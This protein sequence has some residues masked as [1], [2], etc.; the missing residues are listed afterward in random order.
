MERL[1]ADLSDPVPVAD[2]YAGDHWHVACSLPKIAN[3]GGIRLTLWICSAGYGLI[4]FYGMVR[5][6][7]ATFAANHPDAVDRGIVDVDPNAARRKWWAHLALWEGPGPGEPRTIAELARNQPHSILL[8][9]ASA[10]Y[11]EAVSEDLLAAAT[12]IDDHERLAVFSAGARSASHP[13]LAAS[14]IPCD[15]RLSRTF[16]GALGSLNVRCVR[17]ALQNAARC[18]IRTSALKDLF[19][20]EQERLP[21]YQ[22]YDRSPLSDDEVRGYVREA[23]V[24]EPA[25]RPTPLLRSLRDGGKACEHSRFC[26]LFREV[27]GEGRA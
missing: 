16:G 18:G 8:V 2:L 12:L 26:R 13:T 7:A 10:Q 14:F 3:D 11:L 21:R 6:Y 15:A 1:R 4:P 22:T 5:S 20:R 23:L 25:A 27:E 9:A 17:F 19:R 24:A